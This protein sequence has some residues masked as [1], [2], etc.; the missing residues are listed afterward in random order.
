LNMGEQ[1]PQLDALMCGSLWCPQSPIYLQ[2]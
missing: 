2:V 1:T